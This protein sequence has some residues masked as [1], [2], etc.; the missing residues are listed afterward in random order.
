[1]HRGRIILANPQRQR[2]HALPDPNEPHVEHITVGR[3]E[4]RHEP[5][6]RLPRQ[7]LAHRA[8]AVPP[9]QP[10]G[11]RGR[12]SAAFDRERHVPQ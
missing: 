4:A 3:A 5:P 12:R 8:A 10:H 6:R 7:P 2:D 11:A 1:M 9:G